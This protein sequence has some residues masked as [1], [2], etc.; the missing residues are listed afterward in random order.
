MSK[1]SRGSDVPTSKYRERGGRARGKEKD[2]TV[3]EMNTM[4]FWQRVYE[5]RMPT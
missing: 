3:S 1:K 4:G 2:G 5:D